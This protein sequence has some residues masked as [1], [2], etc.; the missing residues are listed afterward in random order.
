[1]GLLSMS[2]I[3]TSQEVP[4]IPRCGSCG[5]RKGAVSPQLEVVGEGAASI[6]V[7]GERPSY[8]E[9]QKGSFLKGGEG[10]FLKN[11]FKK[12]GFSLSQDCWYLTAVSCFSPQPSPGEVGYCR[13]RVFEVIEEKKPEG[14]LLLGKDAVTCLYGHRWRE[15]IGPVDR[16]RGFLI[17]DQ[18]LD[19]WVM[20]TFSPAT[21]LESAS[22]SNSSALESLFDKDLNDFLR[23]YNQPFPEK[24]DYRKEIIFPSESEVASL[25]H[26][27]RS[28]KVSLPA[29]VAFDYETTGLKPQREGHAIVSCA[30][31]WEEEDGSVSAIAFSM[32]SELVG[33]WKWFL[34][35]SEIPKIAANISFEQAWSMVHFGVEVRGW[36][37]DTVLAAHVLDNRSSFSGVKFQSLLFFGITNYDGDVSELM[38]ST[39]KSGNSFNRIYEIDK[40]DLLLYNGMDA[41]LELLLARRQMDLLKQQ[42]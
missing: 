42:I 31:A 16:W 30:M 10:L 2:Q 17:P 21:L 9:D 13:A 34:S 38:K 26:A 28:R 29:C 7:I 33:M 8:Q 39:G 19:C 12:Y 6:L 3:P 18:D 40:Q 35:D 36:V 23:G 24:R 22:R 1:M 14:I 37:W 11:Y 32:T 20:A 4:K 27:W 15:E 5:L 25:L 41:L